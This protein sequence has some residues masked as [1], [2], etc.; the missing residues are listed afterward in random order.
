MNFPGFVYLLFLVPIP[1]IIHF[2]SKRL[3]KTKDFPTLLFVL[4]SDKHL[5]RWFRLKR[6]LLLF[7]RIGIIVSMTL[8][9]SN[10]LIPFPF[11]EGNAR[12]MI[13]D[14]SLSMQDMDFTPAGDVVVPNKG[15]MALIDRAVKKYPTGLLITDA[16]R[17]GFAKLLREGMMY[18]G[19]DIQKMSFPQG[20]IGIV[21]SQIGSTFSGRDISI[22]FTILNQFKDSRKVDLSLVIDEVEIQ[23]KTLTLQSGKNE[24]GFSFSLKE[25]PHK[26]FLKINDDGFHFD[27]IRYLAFSVIPKMK[28]VIY[29][30]EYPKRLLSALDPYSFSV[31]WR[32]EPTGKKEGDMII[33]LGLPLTLLPR[34][35]ASSI[36]GIIC[37]S[38]GDLSPYAT[39]I[40]LRISQLGDLSGIF[41]AP[42]TKS[43]CDIPVTYDCI[44]NTGITLAYFEN[45]DPFIKK[46]ENLLWLPVSL[47]ESDLTLHPIFVPFLYQLISSLVEPGYK[48]N[49]IMDE[50]LVLETS[51]KPAILT[52]D[53]RRHQP[54]RIERGRYLF[55]KTGTPGVYTVLD[56]VVKKGY[57]SVNPDPSESN[58]DTLKTSEREKLFG[59]LNY[60]NGS[61]FFLVFAFL[62]FVLSI[63]LERR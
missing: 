63:I 38:G 25:G 36:P 58:I 44:L 57:I 4:K 53:G 24:I 33:S 45:G 39:C 27:N 47:E 55:S 14:Q 26:G 60:H 37:L 31:K 46:T 21:N 7:I 40:P 18:P 41:D 50:Y 48:M 32:K 62:L 11:M 2:I 59:R 9:A 35:M 34:I 17:N 12:K 20:N 29:S 5:L 23:K 42:W 15:G 49:L 8:V 43:L 16:Q 22:I 56:G 51:Y 54:Q 10:L 30:K 13:L 19:I 3:L 61:N 52:P 1:I 28:I 6:L